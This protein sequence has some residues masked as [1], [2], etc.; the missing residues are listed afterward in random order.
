MINWTYIKPVGWQAKNH[1][2][3]DGYVND[4]ASHYYRIESSEDDNGRPVFYLTVYRAVYR[5]ATGQ[6]IDATQAYYSV[7]KLKAIAAN[8]FEYFGWFTQEG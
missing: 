4:D 5:A 2:T 7:N 6:A 8:H 3:L 1:L